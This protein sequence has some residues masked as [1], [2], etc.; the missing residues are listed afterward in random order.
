[1]RGEKAGAPLLA[2]CAAADGQY[3]SWP[4]VV[5]R[6]N[7]CLLQGKPMAARTPAFRRHAE[8]GAL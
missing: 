3:C 6:S 1:A 4:C 8:A 5:Q 2:R 7:Q